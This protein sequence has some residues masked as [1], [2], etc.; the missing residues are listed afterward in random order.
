[1]IHNIVE[2]VDHIGYGI[3]IDK[4]KRLCFLNNAN[5]QDKLLKDNF[6][7]DHFLYVFRNYED[8]PFNKN[9]T[10]VILR[11]FINLVCSRYQ[12]YG[13]YKHNLC[14]NSMYI[15]DLHYLI[16]I[17]KQHTKNINNLIIYNKWLVS[18][19]YRDN[20]SLSLVGIKN[21][22]DNYTY[23]SDIGQGSSFDKK[24]TK[25]I[26]S[27]MNRYKLVKLPNHMKEIILKDDELLEL[28]KAIFDIDIENILL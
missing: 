22:I 21:T 5:I 23:I 13:Q 15:C 26:S 20:I 25:D 27:Y 6:Y 3:Y 17:W 1:M 28:N 24:D 7:T 18:K 9:T 11:D 16:E 12:K 2:S 4:Y 8:A 10:I 19:D 14:L